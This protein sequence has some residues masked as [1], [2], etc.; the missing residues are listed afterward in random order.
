MTRLHR[1]VLILSAALLAAVGAAPVRGA[2]VPGSHDHPLVSRYAGSEIIKYDTRSFDE[3]GLLVRKVTHYGGKGKN[4]DAAQV[5]EGPVTRI[6]Y[7][8]PAERSTLEVFRNYEAAMAAGG[9]EVLFECSNEACGGRNF[10]HAVVPYDLNFGD[11]YEDQRYQAA[12]LGREEGDVYVALYVVRNTTSGGEKKGR[13]F[14][15][16]DLIETKPMEAGMVTVD[17][18]AMAKQIGAEGHV[19]LYGIYFDFDKADVK[20]ESKPALDE[21]AKLLKEQPTLKLWVVGHTDNVG[22]PGYN[23]NLSRRRAQS[24]V[25]ALIGDYGVESSRLRPEGVGMLAPVAS[26]KNEQGRALNRRVELVES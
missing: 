15:Q 23:V 18:A 19:A 14:V 25:Q 17:A 13:I 21:I 1:P 16:L 4:M 20:P 26:N 8:A 12:R 10:N 6:S 7:R 24:V 22:A 11:N 5:L 9:F 3:Y 2:D